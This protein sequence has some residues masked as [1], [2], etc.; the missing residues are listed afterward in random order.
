MQ[1][2]LLAHVDPSNQVA[3]VNEENNVGIGE[4][5][6]KCNDGKADVFDKRHSYGKIL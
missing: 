3:E 4:I 5:I 2:F 1:V 6:V